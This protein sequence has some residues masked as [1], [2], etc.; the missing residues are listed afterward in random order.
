MIQWYSPDDVALVKESSGVS[1]RDMPFSITTMATSMKYLTERHPDTG[2]EKPDYDM[3]VTI[4]LGRVHLY[5]KNG[6]SQLSCEL[7][8]H[9]TICLPQGIEYYL[10]PESREV[11]LQTTLSAK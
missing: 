8:L 11:I 10:I 6:N 7:E 2:Y 1:C 5:V 4:L 9:N 3:I